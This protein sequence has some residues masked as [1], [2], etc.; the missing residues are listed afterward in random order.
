MIVGLGA[1]FSLL[2]IILV[3]GTSSMGQVL[4]ATVAINSSV[5][6][7]LFGLFFVGIFFPTVCILFSRMLSGRII[8]YIYI[9][10]VLV[11]M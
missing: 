9:Y 1:V 3:A 2:A 6:A 4:P 8:I 5:G 10:I 7:P 11:P